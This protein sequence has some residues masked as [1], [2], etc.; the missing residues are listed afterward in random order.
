MIKLLPGEDRTGQVWFPYAT[1]PT[2]ESFLIVGA[3]TVKVKHETGKRELA[4]PILHLSS[5]RQSVRV[6]RSGCS[7]VRNYVC[8]QRPE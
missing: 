5:G 4:H 7:W 6:E 8:L 1:D 2:A 3:P